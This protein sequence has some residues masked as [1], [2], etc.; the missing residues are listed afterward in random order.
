MRLV[1]FQIHRVILQVFNGLKRTSGF[2]LFKQIHSHSDRCRTKDLNKNINYRLECWA[3]KVCC[4][5]QV[6]LLVKSGKTT[7]PLFGSFEEK[8]YLKP[9]P[10]RGNSVTFLGNITNI[11]QSECRMEKTAHEYKT[12]A[13]F[14]ADNPELPGLRLEDCFK[15][16]HPVCLDQ[17]DDDQSHV[18]A[19]ASL[20][21]HRRRYRGGRDHCTGAQDG[22][23][24]LP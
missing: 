5:P 8:D 10:G 20:S 11:I 12:A 4:L 14:R 18:R 3:L 23:D 7:E 1:L 16:Y 21:I 13:S 17:C 24:S 15:G 9:K 22:E 2:T 19:Q 6:N